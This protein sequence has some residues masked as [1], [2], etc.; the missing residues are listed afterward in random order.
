M[1]VPNF[2]NPSTDNGLKLILDLANCD[3][4]MLT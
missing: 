3:N 2:H 1:Y 4:I